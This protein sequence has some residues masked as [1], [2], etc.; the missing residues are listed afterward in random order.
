[1]A[2]DGAA[3][4]APE[5]TLDGAP[6]GALEGLVDGIAERAAEVEQVVLSRSAG[7]QDCAVFQ[8]AAGSWVLKE[9]LIR[10]LWQLEK[11]G[12]ASAPCGR[13][14]AG[15]GAAGSVR[16]GAEGATHVR[17]RTH[18]HIFDVRHIPR[19]DVHVKSIRT[20]M[21]EDFLQG[22]THA[23]SGREPPQSTSACC[24]LSERG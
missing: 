5:G 7:S 9:A 16:G 15:I 11:S 2:L 22:D 6:K 19:T 13:N 17:T 21:G 20:I 1:M 3:E 8:I 14:T 24:R 12:V 4:G 23:V 10:N 18:L